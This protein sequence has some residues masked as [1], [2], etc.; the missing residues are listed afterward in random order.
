VAFRY[1]R[2]NAYWNEIINYYHQSGALVTCDGDYI[3]GFTGEINP[4]PV[5]RHI[6]SSNL[7][8]ILDKFKEFR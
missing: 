6:S 5:S 8:I 1:I 7:Q 2:I 4:G 3:M